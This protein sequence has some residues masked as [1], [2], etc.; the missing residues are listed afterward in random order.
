M[1]GEAEL[2]RMLEPAVRPAG[3][4]ARPIQPITP[5]EQRDF[6]QLLREAEMT[7]PHA[8]QDVQPMEATGEAKQPTSLIARLGGVNQIHNHGVLAVLPRGLAG[9]AEAGSVTAGMNTD[10]PTAEPRISGGVRF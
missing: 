9:P 4:P 3:V 5:V 2:L 10:D 7:Q 1:A 6:D 8:T